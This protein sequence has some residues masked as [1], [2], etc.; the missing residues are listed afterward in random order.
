MTEE[1]TI[2]MAVATND[3]K[4]L[5]DILQS[6][7][8]IANYTMENVDMLE[9][10]ILNVAI[11][12]GDVKSIQDD[13]LKARNLYKSDYYLNYAYDLAVYLERHEL[14]EFLN[15]EIDK[16]VHSE[17]DITLPPRLRPQNP[18]E[19]P[20]ELPPL[21]SPAIPRNVVHRLNDTAPRD[22]DD[23]FIVGNER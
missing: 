21:P 15:Y 11:M 14:L 2:A 7:T 13:V 4:K 12:Y 17:T 6:K 8:G 10:N 16:L 22:T 3:S 1:T 23:R 5:K 20:S 9:T 19:T 18:V